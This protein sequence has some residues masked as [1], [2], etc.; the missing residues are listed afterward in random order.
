MAVSKLAP[1]RY[2]NFIWP[3]NPRVYSIQFDRRMA[4]QDLLGRRTGLEALGMGRRVMRG[5]GEFAGPQA[6]DQFKALAT[7]FYQD[8]PGVLFHPIWQTTEAYFVELALEQ[9][10]RADY[11]RYSFTFWECGGERQSGGLKESTPNGGGNA[12]VG[13]SSGGGNGSASDGAA[14]NAWPGALCHT[15]ARGDTL[16]AIARKYGVELSELI[17]LNPQLK[18]PNLIYP[19]QKVRVRR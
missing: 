12:G 18:N 3:H 17:A 6:Y 19:G 9:E 16:W 4:R 14:G 8:T 5:E 7:V 15:V 10:P 13:G 11:V 2:K 1:M